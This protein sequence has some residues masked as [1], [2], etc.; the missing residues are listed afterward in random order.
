MRPTTKRRPD[1]APGAHTRPEVAVAVEPLIVIT[2]SAAKITGQKPRGLMK[3][4]NEDPARIARGEA[5]LG[6]P[7]I[8][9]GQ[10]I[11][12]RVAD[13][14]KWV[15]SRAIENGVAVVKNPAFR[16]AVR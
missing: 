14:K 7:W 8:L 1:V 9:I 2:E 10:K 3:W 13:L 16:K 12:Y 15:A 6:P 5:P 11:Y 4:R